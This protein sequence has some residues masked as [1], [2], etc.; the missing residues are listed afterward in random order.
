M[1][2]HLILNKKCELIIKKIKGKH[3]EILTFIVPLIDWIHP[4][5]I[6]VNFINQKHN[7]NQT[8]QFCIKLGN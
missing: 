4:I 2:N 5:Q 3:Y 7:N 1:H 8:Q 6:I